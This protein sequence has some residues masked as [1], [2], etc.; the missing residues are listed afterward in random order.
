VLLL[1]TPQTLNIS[2]A[3]NAGVHTLVRMAINTHADQT[4][5]QFASKALDAANVLKGE[6]APAGN[7][8][9]NG[10]AL[11]KL[12][13]GSSPLDIAAIGIGRIAS[14]ESAK[15]PEGAGAS[16]Y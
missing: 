2:A 15:E 8:T 6:I 3:D 1:P 11:S 16:S 13:K 7:R 9:R 4:V 5:G 10:R 14:L 12:S